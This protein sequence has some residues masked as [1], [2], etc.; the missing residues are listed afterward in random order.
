MKDGQYESS[1]LLPEVPNSAWD[2]VGTRDFNGDGNLDLLWLNTATGTPTIWYL[3]QM[4][5][6]TVVTLPNLP[7]PN[8]KVIGLDDFNQIPA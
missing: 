3:N 6:A 2:L 7:S 4:K 1:V 5:Y 8:F